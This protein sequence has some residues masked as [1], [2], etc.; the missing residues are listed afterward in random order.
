M[1]IRNR[2]ANPK[3]WRALKTMVVPIAVL[4][5]CSCAILPAGGAGTQFTRLIIT[6]TMAAPINPNYVYIVAFNPSTS[7]NPTVQGPVPV[8]GAPWGNGFVAGNCQYFVR[9]DSLQSPNYILYQ[10]TDATL[11][12]YFQTGVPVNYV[13]VTSGVTQ[14]QFE[15]DV[16]QLAPTAA[17]AQA[18]E[19]VQVNFLTMNVVPQGNTGGSKVWDALGDGRIPSE[20]N[21]YI[22]VDLR[23]PGIYN[24]ARYGGL[25]P[26]GDCPEPSLDI[27]DFSVEVRT[28]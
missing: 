3:L 27:I 17:Q 7:P 15:V 8:V 18:L 1:R 28:Q 2:L 5:M 10:F 21:D 19:S 24:N 20:I 22:T 16:N 9:W 13:D 26:Q 14:F 6:W 25:E 12:G 23:G 11:N 4:L